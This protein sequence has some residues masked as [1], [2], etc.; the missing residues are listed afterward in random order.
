MNSS[1]IVGV[2]DLRGKETSQQTVCSISFGTPLID[3]SV[4]P[5]ALLREWSP[6]LGLGKHSRRSIAAYL[7][8]LEELLHSGLILDSPWDGSGMPVSSEADA[9]FL[10]LSHINHHS[11]DFVGEG[12]WSQLD[13]DYGLKRDNLINVE[14]AVSG[15]PRFALLYSSLKSF[16]VGRRMY[17]TLVELALAGQ[18][19]NVSDFTKEELREIFLSMAQVKRMSDDSYNDTY[20]FFQALLLKLRRRNF[21]DHASI[22]KAKD[23]V[24]KF[25]LGRRYLAQLALSQNRKGTPTETGIE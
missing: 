24:D 3:T 22:H 16:G 9:V 7:Q 1:L 23:P 5:V 19:V 6:G 10:C 4:R 20:R 8:F 25:V 15:S 13:G 18:S 17:Q 2:Q 14:D 11:G 12:N 21:I